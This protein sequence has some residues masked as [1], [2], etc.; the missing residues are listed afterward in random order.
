MLLQKAL[1]N[2][3]YL[4]LSKEMDQKNIGIFTDFV[5][6]FT[7]DNL[8]YEIVYNMDTKET[9]L[10]SQQKELPELITK[11]FPNAEDISLSSDYI[12]LAPLLD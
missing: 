4:T 7:I 12:H 2:N 1:G 5:Y 10:I 8:K 3:L 6:F 11:L 9:Y